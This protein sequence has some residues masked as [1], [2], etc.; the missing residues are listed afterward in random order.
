MQL[1]KVIGSVVATMKDPSLEGAKILMIQPLTDDMKPTGYP[2][3]AVDV[4]Q[5][6]GGDL[7]YWI[8]AREASLALPEPFSPVDASIVGIVDCVHQDDVGVKDK[9]DVFIKRK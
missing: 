4:A 2:I 6:G 3:A 5:A 1:A 9:D 7:V 8:T